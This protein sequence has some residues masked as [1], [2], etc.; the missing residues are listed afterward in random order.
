LAE[1]TFKAVEETNS[2]KNHTD[3]ATRNS[4]L[5]QKEQKK[6]LIQFK[7]REQEQLLTEEKQHKSIGSSQQTSDEV[8]C[9]FASA[10][11]FISIPAGDKC[12]ID[13]FEYIEN[14]IYGEEIG[15]LFKAAHGMSKVTSSKMFSSAEEEGEVQLLQEEDETRV[16]SYRRSSSSSSSRYEIFPS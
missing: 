2:T 3:I 5:N 13:G 14:A 16:F 15:R 7:F 6:Q 8:Q 1:D 9:N 10:I 12:R 11:S 4:H